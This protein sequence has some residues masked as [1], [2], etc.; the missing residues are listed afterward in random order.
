MAMTLSPAAELA[1]RAS[2]TLAIEYGNGPVR[3]CDI[4]AV[5]DMQ[6]DYTAKVLG[7]LSRARL[8]IPIRGKNGG[9]RLAR[10]PKDIT[11]LDV[12]EAVEGPFS[13]NLCQKENPECDQAQKCPVG[14]VWSEIQDFA[15]AK[16]RGKT[17]GECVAGLAKLMPLSDTPIAED[18]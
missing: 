15:V 11:L 10:D 17:L 1:M 16:L 7:Y 8:V 13:L 5:R 2:I 6:R 3:L 9:Y 4:C 14:A 12:I 18:E